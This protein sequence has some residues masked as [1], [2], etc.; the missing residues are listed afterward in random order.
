MLA[1]YAAWGVD[2][3]KVDCIANNPYKPSE[4]RQIAAAIQKTGRPIVLSLSPGPTNPSHA[5]EIR[6]YA[7]MWRISNDIWDGW[8]FTPQTTRRRLPDGRARHLRPP[9]SLD[10]PS[11]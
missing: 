10:R 2:F 4:I 1:L 11:P 8:T 6:T 7:Q 9:V 5:A 3:L